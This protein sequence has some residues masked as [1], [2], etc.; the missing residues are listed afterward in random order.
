MNIYQFFQEVK[1]RPKTKAV[2][3]EVDPNPVVNP[4]VC[5]NRYDF[6]SRIKLVDGKIKIKLI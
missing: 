2:K 6:Y 1:M 3:T 4:Q 5:E